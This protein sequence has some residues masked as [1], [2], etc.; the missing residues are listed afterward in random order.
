MDHPRAMDDLS[1]IRA[2]IKVTINTTMVTRIGNDLAEGA[3]MAAAPPGA[4]GPQC[5]INRN[6]LNTKFSSDSL[7]ARRD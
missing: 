3:T 7:T 2:T 1:T 4:T 5:R 6:Q